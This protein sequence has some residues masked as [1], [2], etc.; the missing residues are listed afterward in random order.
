MAIAGLV[1][2]LLVLACH[3]LLDRMDRHLAL[4]ARLVDPA[5]PPEKYHESENNTSSLEIH[6]E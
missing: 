3:K 5:L 2:A 1:I 4:V 6:S